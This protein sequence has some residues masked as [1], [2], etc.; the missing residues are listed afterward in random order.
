M[1]WEDRAHFFGVAAR[2]M[3]EILVDHARARQAGKSGGLVEKLPLDQ[4]L[5]FS[6]ARSRELIEWDNALKL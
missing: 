6:P 5:E 1:G 4:A 2:L 3:R